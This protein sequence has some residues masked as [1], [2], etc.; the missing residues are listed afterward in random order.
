MT[1]VHLDVHVQVSRLNTQHQSILMYMY[2]YSASR[3]GEEQDKRAI[4][5]S[6]KSKEL[7]VLG[8]RLQ[9]QSRN[10]FNTR[11]VSL[12]QFQTISQYCYITQESLLL[13]SKIFSSLPSSR[14]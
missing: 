8:D 5:R 4:S 9:C 13:N 11:C 14:K 3:N 2:R 10:S 7:V 6:G 12:S 1:P